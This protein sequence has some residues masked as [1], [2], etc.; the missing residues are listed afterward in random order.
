MLKVELEKQNKKL[1]KLVKEAGELGT[2]LE[3]D[4]ETRIEVEAKKMMLAEIGEAK[5]ILIEDYYQKSEDHKEKITNMFSN[6]VDS[7]FEK[8]LIIPQK[9]L[10][11]AKKGE[12]YDEA[13]QK[14]KII[15]GVDEG[16]LDEEMKALLL[17]AKDEIVKVRTE[18]DKLTGENLEVQQDAQELAAQ[19]YLHQISDKAGLTKKQKTSV[20]DIIGDATD[21][22]EIDRKFKVISELQ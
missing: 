17:E 7:V 9:V 14:L 20:F 2:K 6:F 22:A 13:I 4:M 16:I 1:I 18:N 12:M 5:E 11:Y 19:V 15:I 3:Q 8:E 10:E 21:R